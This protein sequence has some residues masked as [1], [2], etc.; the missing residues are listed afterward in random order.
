MDP[1]G[2]GDQESFF[3]KLNNLYNL[4]SE[5]DG[6]VTGMAQ[7]NSRF[8]L[9]EE[10]IRSLHRIAL[11]RLLDEAGSYRKVAVSLN[12]SPYVPPNWIEVPALMGTLCGYV[13]ENWEHADLIHLSA[14]CL[15][16]MNW[17]HPFRNGNG[18]IARAVCYMV[19]CAKHGKLLPTK[20][21]VVQ[22][23]MS[24]KPEHDALLRQAD[25]VYASSQDIKLTVQGLEQF[26][27][28]L[29]TIQLKANF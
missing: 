1:D 12:G 23:I 29:L 11:H 20:N 21:T 18:R 6:I 4:Q 10:T 17:V 9:S 25:G 14:F 8:L 19:M 27:T 24:L 13:N 26:L 28:R 16:R 7:A 3:Q 22:Q 2:N 15:W 5:V